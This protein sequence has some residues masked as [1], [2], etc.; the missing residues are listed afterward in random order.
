MSLKQQKKDNK[1]SPKYYGL[2]N[3][4]LRI[5]SMDYK[6]KLPPS[7]HVH[8]VFY[9]SFLK[10]IIGDKI[11]IPTILSEIDEGK[12]LLQPETIIE[13]QLKQLQN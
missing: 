2:Y 11:P 6:L 1:L 9:V 10:K 7:S 3:V 12:I 5:G 8:S 13:T 4:L